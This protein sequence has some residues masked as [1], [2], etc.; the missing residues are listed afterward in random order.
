[1]SKG[2]KKQLSKFFSEVEQSAGIEYIAL[3]NAGPSGGLTNVVASGTKYQKAKNRVPAKLTNKLNSL[4][5]TNPGAVEVLGYR[6]IQGDKIFE[7]VTAIGNEKRNKTFSFLRVG[8]NRLA[9]NS[10]LSSSRNEA[11]YTGIGIIIVFVIAGFFFAKLYIVQPFEKTVGFVKKRLRDM[12]DHLTGEVERQASRSDQVAAASQEMT[13]TIVEIAENAQ[14]AADS[15][16][17]AV[18]VA[19]EGGK[20]NREVVEVIHELQ[21]SIKESSKLVADLEEHST[22][23]GE[24]VDVINEIAEQTNLL[25]LNATIEAAR[26]GKH[27]K[28]FAVV[29]DEVRRLAER[30]TNATEEIGSTIE[31]IQNKTSHVTSSMDED[32]QVALE[33]TELIEEA[34]EKTQDVITHINEALDRVSEVADATDQQSTASEEI[35]EN[36][37]EVSSIAGE[38]SK[39]TNNVVTEIIS[40]IS[41][42]MASLIGADMVGIL[43]S[44]DND[45]DNSAQ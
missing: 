35:S 30:T 12:R 33:S 2:T 41:T 6:N 13:T 32:H 8:V 34:E 44:S 15:S 16:E 7:A 17:K 38:F 10:L 1:L 43:R 4:E 19:E 22:E 5:L 42:R 26:A 9:V 23:I 11:I 14:H 25:A 39:E 40:Q 31:Q 29:A 37:Q 28:G 24:V 45:V 20:V 27:G 21:S 3:Q 18:A 36:I